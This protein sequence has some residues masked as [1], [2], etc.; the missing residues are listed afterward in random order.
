[1]ALSY[2]N[3]AEVEVQLDRAK[4]RVKKITNKIKRLSKAKLIPG[5]TEMTR[6]KK[7]I[8]REALKS[9]MWQ[10]EAEYRELCAEYRGANLL[11]Q[12]EAMAAVGHGLIEK[13]LHIP[14]FGEE[15][16]IKEVTL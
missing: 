14:D 12:A 11:A 10:F 1:M 4:R 3:H 6:E 16:E 15:A 2:F 7:A 8:Q 9:A 5:R 13:P